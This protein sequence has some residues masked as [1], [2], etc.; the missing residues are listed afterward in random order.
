MLDIALKFLKDEL[1]SYIVARTGSSLTEV[2][3]AKI[4]DDAGK[5]ALN[6]DSIGINLVNIE[7]ERT[8]KEQL[9]KHTY[10]NGQHI[11]LE[12]ELRLNLYVLFATK[13]LQYDQGL[14][15][16]SHVVT[17]FQAH[18]VFTPVRNPGLD[19][20][21]EKMIVELQS[22]SYDQLSQIWTY[23]GGKQ[24]PSLLYKVR[25]VVVQDTEPTAIKPPITTI[26]TTIENQ[27]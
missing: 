10:V 26:D 22:L 13:F 2:S 6:D 23:V 12:P 15:Y 11:T 25:M 18:S 20:R 14:K 1:S 16:L 4:V 7:E 3:L 5:W 27:L 19:S 8:V 17:F 9:P 21:I 24:L